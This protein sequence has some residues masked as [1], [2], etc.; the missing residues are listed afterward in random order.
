MECSSH[1]FVRFFLADLGIWIQT[2]GE[3]NPYKWGLFVSDMAEKWKLVRTFW[4]P[5]KS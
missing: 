3:D 5:L 1:G 4:A 2:L